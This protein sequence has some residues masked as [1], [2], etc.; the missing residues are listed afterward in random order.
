VFVH[1]L[2]GGDRVRS[3]SWAVRERFDDFDREVWRARDVAVVEQPIPSCLQRVADAAGA[4]GA[5]TA[6]GADTPASIRP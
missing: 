4:A 1:R 5:A 6:T 2:C 3:R